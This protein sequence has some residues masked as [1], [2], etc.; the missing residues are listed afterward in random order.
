[1]K[2][3]C[4]IVIPARYASVRFPAKVLARVAGKSILRWCHEAAVRSG[5]GRVI[6]ATEDRKV[7]QAANSMGAEA[8]LT[9]PRCASGSDRVH[10]AASGSREPFIINYQA[11]E[12][13]MQPDTLRR[14]AARLRKNPAYDMVTAA[15]P[16]KDGR[17]VSDPNCVKIA[18]AKD[19]RA[20][21]FSRCPIPYHHPLSKLARNYPWQKH[22]GLYGY[23]RKS[24][25]RFV[26]LP[27]SPLEL[28]ERLEQL[29]AL[30]AGM[31]VSVVTVPRL[32]PAVDVPGD[33][34]RAQFY[35]GK[36]VKK[37]QNI[38]S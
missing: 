15:A 35:Y 1:M 18:A 6:I 19:G 30:E 8:V 14:V 4:L 36:F 21:Y 38:Y 13:F 23:R 33:I 29:R 17:E 12:P 34:K 37:C 20:L 10:E 28:L 27:P 22:C 32:G 2:K 26:A 25:D 11:D 16:L 31:T 9:S 3:G 7:L 24:L 5:V